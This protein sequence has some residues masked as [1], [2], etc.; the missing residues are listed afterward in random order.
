MPPALKA[1]YLMRSREPGVRTCAHSA[2]AATAGRI[3]AA[4]LHGC[5]LRHRRKADVIFCR[6]VIIYF[7]RP[8]QQRILSR[9]TNCLVPGGYLFVGHAETLHEWICRSSPVAPDAVQEDR[10]RSLTVS[11]A[12][13][14]RAAGRI[15]A[16]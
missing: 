11:V 13:G 12:G 8:T 4:E 3:S 14:L 15:A 7:D 10:W 1:K 16:W 9:L 6:N 2:G 5:R